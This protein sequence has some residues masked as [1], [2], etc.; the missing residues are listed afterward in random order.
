MGFLLV[1][2]T[3]LARARVRL[4]TMDRKRFKS[5]SIVEDK[6]YGG[7]LCC[8]YIHYTDNQKKKK[9]RVGGGM[10][11]TGFIIEFTKVRTKSTFSG[12]RKT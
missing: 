7:R 6:F 8:R 4:L 12:T 3:I 11:D 2:F 9:T 5:V 1:R 10:T